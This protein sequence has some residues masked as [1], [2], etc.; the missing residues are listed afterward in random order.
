MFATMKQF[1]LYVW[2]WCSSKDESVNHVVI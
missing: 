1:T 2:R